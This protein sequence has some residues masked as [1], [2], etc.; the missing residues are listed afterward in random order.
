MNEG[1][2]R[3]L[4]T[5]LIR[6][7]ASTQAMPVMVLHGAWVLLALASWSH[8]IGGEA[9]AGGIPRAVLRA[10]AWLGGVDEGGHGDA[11]NLLGVLAKLSLVAY[12]IGALW[13]RMFGASRPLRWWLL[14]LGSGV[15]AL[16]GYGLAMWPSLPAG[17][18]GD[19]AFVI[20]W[21][22]LLAA[23]SM[24]WAV[25]ARRGGERLVRSMEQR[26]RA[27][28]PGATGPGSVDPV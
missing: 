10:Y 19:A 15:V 25:L 9:G 4:C 13:Q 11:S 24:A 27:T 5:Q 17:K 2:K 14:A 8:A 1:L 21:L 23:L 6:Y 16:A 26:A 3:G 20:G 7:I 12:A 18:P 22:A 28:R